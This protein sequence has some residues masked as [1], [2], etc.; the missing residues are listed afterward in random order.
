MNTNNKV[1]VSIIIPVYNVEKYLTECLNSILNQSYQN[2]EIIIINDGSIDNSVNIAKQYATIDS[3]IKIIDQKNSGVS[4]ARN[5]GIEIAKGDYICFA[6]ADDYLM[7]DY[8]EYLLDLC[9]ENNAE[10]AYTKDM[11]TTFHTE[12]EHKHKVTVFTPEKATEEILCYNVPIGVYSKLFKS[13]F[14]YKNKLK[15]NEKIYI[16]EGFNF[17]I[18]CFQRANKIVCSNHRIYFYRRDNEASAMTKFKIG[19]CE[20]ALNAIDNIK[21]NLHI[22][23]KKILKAWKFAYW[24]THLDMLCWIKNSH[25]QK[26]HPS[27]YKKCLH[28]SKKYAYLSFFLPTKKTEKIRA[29]LTFISPNIIA[30]LLNL[31]SQYVTNKK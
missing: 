16:G 4:A 11:F 23:N 19:K 22:K 14:L 27:L 3:R 30:K 18:D 26:E 24:H 25:A 6:D 13:S 8:I 10:I 29:L 31:R 5:K 1:L 12:K 28:V 17:N 20:M 7:P 15:F 21:E 2:I 9:V